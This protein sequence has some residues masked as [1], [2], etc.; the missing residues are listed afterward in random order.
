ME[1]QSITSLLDIINRRFEDRP[2]A[3]KDID[4][5]LEEAGLDSFGFIQLIIDVEEEYGCQI[6][7]SM[8]MLSE[9]NTVTKI[10]ELVC[11]LREDQL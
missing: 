11:K 6:P 7:D 9:L 5:P 2:L 10:Y 4:L 1:P 3:K 8:L